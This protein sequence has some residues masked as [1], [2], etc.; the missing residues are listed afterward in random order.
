[1]RLI[2]QDVLQAVPCA[3]YQVIYVTFAS[4]ED[5]QM[6][7]LRLV[8]HEFHWDA[9][10]LSLMI[11]HS[12]TFVRSGWKYKKTGS[13]HKSMS[14]ALIVLKSSSV[15]SAL[16][17]Y[18]C[19]RTGTHALSHQQTAPPL[20]QLTLI[21]AI[22]VRVILSKQTLDHALTVL[23]SYLAATAASI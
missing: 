17:L 3:T 14:S 11:L 23:E 4:M 22:F 21:V 18:K 13:T 15:R 20:I 2:V 8:A 9:M 19:Q 5:L 6:T 12:V 7:T 16:A 10:L 1:M